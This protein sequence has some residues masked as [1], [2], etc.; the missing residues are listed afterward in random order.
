MDYF[1]AYLSQ[2]Y[3]IVV[4]TSDLGAVRV[5][6][7]GEPR[8]LRV[9]CQPRRL[10][11]SICCYVSLHV[12]DCSPFT[13]CGT[14]NHQQTAQPTIDKLDPNGFVS[15][16]LYRDAAK[17]KRGAYIKVRR[18]H[19]EKHSLCWLLSRFRELQAMSYGE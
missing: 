13:V 16:R 4:F 1:L 18:W 7:E 9:S 14:G 5:W 19:E 6:P 15:Y 3:E 2:F 12:S 8:C 11:F 10:C 17:Y